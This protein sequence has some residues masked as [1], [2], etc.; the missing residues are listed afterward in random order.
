MSAILTTSELVTAILTRFNAKIS[1]FIL[2]KLI[3]QIRLTLKNLLLSAKLPHIE[4]LTAKNGFF[5]K[6][7]RAKIRLIFTAT[8]DQATRMTPV[9]RRTVRKSFAVL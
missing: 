4:L 6:N 8:P 5:P 7:Q 1:R 9:G 2:N 3:F